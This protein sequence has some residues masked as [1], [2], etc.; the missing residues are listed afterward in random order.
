MDDIRRV[1]AN[2]IVR[3]AGSKGW[4]EKVVLWH[5]VKILV[6]PFLHY[7]EYMET[8]NSI[9]DYCT[10]EDGTVHAELFDLASRAAVI[11]AYALVRLPSEMDDLMYVVFHSDLY[12]FI[13]S[14]VCLEQTESIVRV[15]REIVC[16]G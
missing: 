8:I 4:Q 12:D 2:T 13:R 16:R 14:E 5:G 3:M 6:H 10:T 9:V 11:G 1:P 15:A 7:S